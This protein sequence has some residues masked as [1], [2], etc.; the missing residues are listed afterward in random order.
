MRKTRV[1][2]LSLLCAAMLWAM[3]AGAAPELPKDPIVPGT[4]PILMKDVRAHVRLLEFVL[5]TRM[6]VAQK[7][8]FLA[9]IKKEAADFDT[10][11]REDFRQGTE[12][13]ESIGSM[14]EMQREAVRV[15]LQGDFLESAADNPEDTA[16]QLYLALA[17]QGTRVL[18]QV[19]SDTVTIQDL[20][21]L[22]EW[23][24]FA[25][26]ADRTEPLTSPERDAVRSLVAEGFAGL[27]P[28][29]QKS[30]CGF[31]ALWYQ[32]RAAWQCA[33]PDQKTGWQKRIDQAWG[34]ASRQDLTVA[35]L[36]GLLLPDVWADMDSVARAAG[37]R[38][39]GW[40]ATASL[41]IW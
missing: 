23:A 26:K 41:D 40:I 37:E 38:P 4:P 16:A 9:A 5:Q 25:R 11:A 6:T 20:E 27:P 24:E 30:L 21:A 8:H 13:L 29:V 36:S 10:E 31:A 28:D 39:E 19:G 33:T 17:E 18:A 2:S 35:R 22:V 14:S 3:S 12:L 32:I 34:S 1:L 7:E 15:M